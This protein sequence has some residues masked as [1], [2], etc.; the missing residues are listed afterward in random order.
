MINRLLAIIRKDI[1]LRFS[2]A[3]ELLFFLILPVVFTFLLGGASMG[4]GSGT[5]A[6]PVIMED[7]G[8][9]AQRLFTELEAAPSIT[10]RQVSPEEATTLLEEETAVAVLLVPAGFSEQLA[11]GGDATLIWRSQA[12]DAD[13]LALQQTVRAAVDRISRAAQ[14]ARLALEVA[15]ARQPFSGDAERQAYYEASLQQATTLL[16]EAPQRIEVQQAL[17]QEE[18]EYSPAAQASA[19]QLITWVF[20]PLLGTSALFAYERQ[21]GTLR[22]LLTTPTSKATFL[23]GAI[24]SQMVGAL[25]QMLPLIAFGIFV[26]NLDWGHSPAALLLLLVSFALAAVAMG[27][28]LGTFISSEGQANGLSIMLGMAMALLGGCWYPL[29]LFPPG[30]QTAVHVLPTTWAMQ[31]FLDLIVRGGGVAAVMPEVGV[32]LAFAAI[33]FIVGVS[34]FR[35]E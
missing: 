23:L 15:E 2:S 13:A 31:G 18:D 17:P 12:N 5:L 10:P 7:E 19:G 34:R 20:I 24:S 6:L 29:E 9:L 30:V 1:L 4:G 8:A 21:R 28:M 16:D 22:R 33:F 3:S 26:L 27:A 32:L 25:A 14:A 11:Q 35:Y